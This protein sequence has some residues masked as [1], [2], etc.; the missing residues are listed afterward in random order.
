MRAW[1]FVALVAAVGCKKEVERGFPSDIAPLEDNLADPVSSRKQGDLNFVCGEADDEDPSYFWCHARGWVEAPI[2]DVYAATQEPDVNVDRREVSEWDVTWNVDPDAE[3]S[4]QI[5]QVVKNIVTV[6]YSAV[7]AH[8]VHQGTPEEPEVTWCLFD[9]VEGD[10]LIQVFRG[11]IVLV[12]EE[13]GLTEFQY[14]EHLKTPMRNETQVEQTIRDVYAD[15][16][17]HVEGRSL[18]DF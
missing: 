2:A 18:P 15:V 13:D 3:V 5:D 6:E 17:A 10:N 8:T 16:I 9:T 7:W 4:Y 12:A 14:I 11:S 1:L